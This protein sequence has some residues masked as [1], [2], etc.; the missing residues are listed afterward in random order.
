MLVLFEVPTHKVGLRAWQ[1]L[2]LTC[3]RAWHWK[4]VTSHRNNL[5]KTRLGCSAVQIARVQT[6]HLVM[7]M[8]TDF[9]R[10][11]Y[12]NQGS[13]SVPGNALQTPNYC[14]FEKKNVT[15]YALQAANFADLRRAFLSTKPMLRKR[16]LYKYSLFSVIFWQEKILAK[17]NFCYVYAKHC[18]TQLLEIY[19]NNQASSST[20]LRPPRIERSK[21]RSRSHSRSRSRHVEVGQRP[22][23][24]E[25]L[26]RDAVS[27]TRP[28]TNPLP[29]ELKWL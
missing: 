16:L 12:R 7:S 28:V 9:F 3:A 4:Q 8:P 17:M 11:V 5:I 10:H 29:W 14:N 22:Y 24:S 13:K 2:D 19:S 27:R 20:T 21:S 15:G 23:I 18:K 6:L 25:V 26:M 1:K